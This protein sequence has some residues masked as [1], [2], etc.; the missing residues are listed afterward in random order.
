MNPVRSLFTIV[1][2]LIL[3][4]VATPPSVYAQPLVSS[5]ILI[6]NSTADAVDAVPGDGYCNTTNQPPLPQLKPPCTLRAAIMEAN[7]SFGS[8]TIIF[9]VDGTFA[10][11]ITGADEDDTHSG[12]LDITDNLT[13]RG[14]GTQQTIIDG[15]GTTLNDRIFHIDPAGAGLEVSISFLT[16]QNGHAYPAAGGGGVLSGVCRAPSTPG[17]DPAASKSRLTLDHVNVRANSVSGV[18]FASGGGIQ[19]Y[20]YLHLTHSTID[21][22]NATVSGGLDNGLAAIAELDQV[23]ISNNTGN[24]DTQGTPLGTGGGFTNADTAMMTISN[25]Q[26]VNNKAPLGSGG[27]IVNFGDLDLENTEISSNKSGFWGGGI[28]SNGSIDMVDVAIDQN[29]A[30]RSGGGIYNHTNGKLTLNRVTINDNRTE[31]FLGALGGGGGGARNSGTMNLTNVTL[32]H[33][34]ADNG[35]Y[36]GG[37]Y[38]GISSTSMVTATLTNV[39]LTGNQATKGGGI[40]NYS[41]GTVLVVNT[42]IANSPN[43]GNCAGRIISNGH[44]LDNQNSCGFASTGD[45]INR[46]PHLYPLE[47]N[48]GLISTRRLGAGSE[49]FVNEFGLL[50]HGVFVSAAVDAGNSLYCPPTD[51]RGV[52]RPIGSSCDIG[53]YEFP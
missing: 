30:L 29:S 37:I 11:T 21:S 27:G 53:A 22:N 2:A 42:I 6:V 12:D 10:L 33:N 52:I 36:G 24:L 4:G 47:D 31:L 7:A 35:G 18:A 43:G 32:S 8:D 3:L 45:I 49:S 44:N 9:T 23:V 16:I 48:G 15:G 39:T 13:I 20:G 38:N 51:G 50:I 17:C 34:S 5:L 19:N 41:A 1:V 40:F 14:N 28:F 25:S 46:D 26:I